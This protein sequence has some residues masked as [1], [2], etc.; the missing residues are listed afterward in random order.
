M[1]NVNEEITIDEAR[2]EKIEREE[3]IDREV[4]KLSKELSYSDRRK[5]AL[6][7]LNFQESLDLQNSTIIIFNIEKI[8]KSREDFIETEINKITDINLNYEEKL[9]KVLNDLNSSESYEQEVKEE[10]KKESEN[11]SI[12]SKNLQKT[13]DETM[14]VEEG[15]QI[16][17]ESSDSNVSQ[18]GMSE[19]T[20]DITLND[21]Y[22]ETSPG[23]KYWIENKY[24]DN[25]I[26]EKTNLKK[27]YLHDYLGK[28]Y[29]AFI[30]NN[31]MKTY[32]FAISQSFCEL[33]HYKIPK[34][35]IMN[36]QYKDEYGLFFCGRHIKEFNKN[37][38]PDEMI[39]DECMKKNMEIYELNKNKNAKH[40]LININGRVAINNLKDKKYHCVGK[41][42]DGKEVKCCC[43]GEFSCK[44]CDSLNTSKTYY[45]NKWFI[46][47]IFE[48]KNKFI[49]LIIKYIF[50]INKII[51][52][53]LKI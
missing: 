33:L 45:G 9:F 39:C 48:K 36:D 2:K 7:N 12:D 26:S 37:C 17:K 28:E 8:R 43:P 15:K 31:D 49:Y 38:S 40:I 41:F 27:K 46:G 53:L 10:N 3:L 5:I 32:I 35:E 4:K 24:Y 14:K 25:A 21:S 44:A 1:I 11:E 13:M 51:I 6:E 34:I 50:I 52:I 18:S 19:S 47:F 16:V 29:F 42:I 20:R 30:Y 22:Y 23:E